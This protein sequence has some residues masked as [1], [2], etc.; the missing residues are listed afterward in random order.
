MR[1]DRR[2][3]EL[4]DRF[5]AEVRVIRARLFEELCRTRPDISGPELLA[6]AQA[7][8]DRVL[9][10]AFAEDRGLAPSGT[11]ERVYE[12]RDRHDARPLW[13][14]MLAMFR[15]VHRRGG[16]LDLPG[17][18]GARFRDLS[19]LERL[20][21]SDDA[22]LALKAIGRRGFVGEVSVAALGCIFERSLADLSA[23][24][25]EGIF[26]T[27]SFV[28]SFLV[29]ET[30]GRVMADA[31]GRAQ[32]GRSADTRGRLAALESYRNDLRSIRVLD[33]SCGGGAL[34]VAAFDALAGEIERAGRDIVALGGPEA[35]PLDRTRGVL[36]E[37]LFGIDTNGAS[38]EVAKLSLWLK[39]GERGEALPALD[40]TILRGNSVVS[41]AALD[42][43]AFDWATGRL[44]SASAEVDEDEGASSMN[45]RWR[46]GFDV[47]LGNPPYVR[48][49]RF[50]AFKGHWRDTF[51]VFDGSADVFVYFI[52]R[53]LRLL[54]PGGRLGFIVSNKWLRAAYA[55]ELR[56]FI[57]RECTVERLVDFGHAPIFPGADAFPC[58]ITARKA[59]PPPD[60]AVKVTLYPREALD[61]G[62]LAQRVEASHAPVA[63][64]TLG[65]AAWTLE[66]PGVRALFD[67]LRKNGAPLS[68]YAEIKPYYGIKTGCNE[69][70]LVD[71][72][73]KERLCREDPRSAE[74]LKKYLRG[75]DLARWSP[76]WAN[77]WLILLKSSGDHRWPWSRSATE[78]AAARVFAQTYPALYGHLRPL[79]GKL[80]SRADRGRFWWELRSC[81]YY[82]SFERAK[83]IYPDIL[84]QSSFCLSPAATYTNNTAYLL[85]T[86]DLWL[87]C[88]LNSPVIW[89]Y[90]WGTAQHAKDEALRMFSESVAT[91]PIA[92]PSPRSHDTALKAAAQ[93]ITRTRSVQRA[94]ADAPGILE[95]KAKIIELE[96]AVASSVHAAYGLNEAD[97]A[98]LRQTSPPRAPPGL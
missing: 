83:L 44:T 80:R 77:L 95:M 8:L 25:T 10:I 91:I 27:P 88:C 40:H 24:K 30:L 66:P 97:L 5:Y 68:E 61:E 18:S 52:E 37:N 72:A 2:E 59:E 73:T 53:G 85:P 19:A 81:A 17:M 70:F 21:V 69:A 41:D 46:E 11:L 33:P 32:A 58:I 75:Q 55:G 89:S 4:F 64:R 90:L 43:W 14:R 38:V 96:R 71:Q 48:H 82:E 94:S 51:R 29:R 45:A 42:P 28:S 7:I 22:C 20:E 87:L 92:A 39:A 47:V 36:K 35:N 3:R 31:W 65:R 56:A 74:I 54:K 50:A 15:G 67:K 6:S 79:E 34:L 49:E 63:Q 62:Q 23:R 12:R 13:E 57:A 26:Y 84:W 76:E 16:G 86:D 9:F 1:T 93:I 98:L 60:H 78:D